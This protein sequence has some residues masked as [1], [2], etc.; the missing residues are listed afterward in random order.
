MGSIPIS[1]SFFLSLVF[2]WFFTSLSVLPGSCWA[3]IDHLKR[4]K[5]KG[6][7][8]PRTERKQRIKTELRRRIHCLKYRYIRIGVKENCSSWGNFGKSRIET[9]QIK[10]NRN[11]TTLTISHKIKGDLIKRPF[12]HSILKILP[13]INFWPVFDKKMSLLFFCKNN[14]FL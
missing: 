14:P 11:H 10:S 5:Q 13:S 3:I 4:V 2:Q 9:F 1:E 12:E 8:Q 7:G 6:P